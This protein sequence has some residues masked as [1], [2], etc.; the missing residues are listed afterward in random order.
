MTVLC[1]LCG[2]QSGWAVYAPEPQ[3]GGK[4]FRAKGT[5]AAKDYTYLG[6]TGTRD[7]EDYYYGD[8]VRAGNVKIQP[9]ISYTREYDSNI[10]LTPTDRQS[11]WINR[12]DWGIDAEAPLNE[13]QYVLYSGVQSLTEWFVGHDDQ[14]HTDW[15]YQ[16]GA[17]ANYNHFSVEVFEDFRRTVDRA[18]TELTQRIDRKENY[19]TGLLTVPLAR[20]F[21][22]NEISHYNLEFRDPGQKIGNRWELREIP[23]IGMDIGDRTQALFEYAIMPIR[24]DEQSDRNGL[25]QQPAVGLRG[26]LGKGDLTAYQA[27]VG[28]ENRSYDSSRRKDFSSVVFRGDIRY[29]PSDLTELSAEVSRRPEESVTETNSYISRNDLSLRYRRKVTDYGVFHAGG[30]AGLYDYSSKRFDSFWQAFSKAEVLL[31]GKFASVFGEYRF[32]QRHS[33]QSGNDYV[34]H[35]ASFGVKLEM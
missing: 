34:D 1:L 19:L 13:G 18:G 9:R 8:G 31:P 33:N 23:R 7:F 27:W 26:F 17:Q 5:M 20:F 10:F 25:S 22:E 24:Y 30:T 28:W 6:R 11:D 2:P 35:I 4:Y 29:R 21:F 14:N 3:S 32:S 15:I 12:L 16:G